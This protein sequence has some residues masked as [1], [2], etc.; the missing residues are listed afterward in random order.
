MCLRENVPLQKLSE[1]GWI[2]Y[3]AIDMEKT[4]R[5]RLEAHGIGLARLSRTTKH[6]LPPK[7]I[8][9]LDQLIHLRN[10]IAHGG[11]YRKSDLIWFEDGYRNVMRILIGIAEMKEE[12]SANNDS[13]AIRS[14]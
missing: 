12:A 3:L 10:R 13:T 14:D 11:S 6:P 7:T 9:Q 5:H 1:L 2:L 8:G 4:L